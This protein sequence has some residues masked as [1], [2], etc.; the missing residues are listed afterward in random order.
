MV[1]FHYAVTFYVVVNFHFVVT[2]HFKVH[3]IWGDLPLHDDARLC[4][5]ILIE[6]MLYFV[7]TFLIVGQVPLCDAAPTCGDISLH[8]KFSLYRDVPLWV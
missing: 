3:P 8:I 7:D 4:G 5:D 6:V 1:T 2:F